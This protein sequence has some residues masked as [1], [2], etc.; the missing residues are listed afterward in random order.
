ML[1]TDRYI[2]WEKF[3]LLGSLYIAQAIPN[4]FFKQALP[5][6]MRQQGASLEAIGMLSF[7]ALPWMIR[8]LWSP[9]VDRYGQT[10]WGHY[11]VWIIIMQSLMILLSGACILTPIRNNFPVLIGVLLLIGF[12]AATQDTGTD[13]LAVGMLNPAER[14][15]GNS[16]QISGTCIGGIIGG[17][18]LLI[19]LGK[20][21]WVNCILVMLACLI[22][23]TLPIVFH[24]ERV[25]ERSSDRKSLGYWR[26]F[27]RFFS[28]RQVFGWLGPMMLFAAASGSAR[29]MFL[30]LLVDLELSV[31]SIGFIVGVINNIAA[32]IGSLIAGAIVNYWGR[33]RSLIGFYLLK[34]F[35][36]SSYLILFLSFKSLPIDYRMPAIYLVVILF[37]FSFCMGLTAVYHTMMD[38]CHADSA[39]TDFSIQVSMLMLAGLGTAGLSG[40]VAAKI[41]YDGLF[42]LCTV[43]C[44]L[45]TFLLAK[46]PVKAIE[47]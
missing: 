15:L 25:I 43:V 13:A 34:T 45:S 31:E 11:K 33:Q 30:P 14:S 7:L 21:G 22:L 10:S 29:A 23:A 2:S 32:I 26:S 44:L 37:Q 35:A 19:M 18:G 17:G 41:G 5:I 39:A 3:G 8:F 28:N 40:F 9:L 16:L 27:R 38:C 42:A 1:S 47:Q 46:N 24:Q 36:V 20:W 12:V 4:T 6:F